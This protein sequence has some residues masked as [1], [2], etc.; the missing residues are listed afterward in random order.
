MKLPRHRPE[1][2]S[3][4]ALVLKYPAE[5]AY[6]HKQA[7]LVV[8]AAAVI[9]GATLDYSPGSLAAVD[10]ILEGFRSDGL[11][12]ERMAETLFTIGC[13]VGEV[14]VLNGQ[15]TWKTS[16][17]T[18]MASFTGAPMVVKLGPEQYAN[19]IDKVYDLFED[20]PGDSLTNFYRV[21]TAS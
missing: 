20:G 11:A 3:N 21:V 6:A 19:P 14:L 7:D 16:A 18:P 9:S 5:P 1:G 15:G 13:Y 17:R 10:E 2:S 8:Q 4:L 12:V